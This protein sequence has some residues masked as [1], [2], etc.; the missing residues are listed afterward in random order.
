MC[1]FGPKKNAG[2]AQI[3]EVL[4]PIHW[5]ARGHRLAAY[6]SVWFVLLVSYCLLTTSTFHWEGRWWE[7]LA[8]RQ[9]IGQAGGGRVRPCCWHAWRNCEIIFLTKER[10]RKRANVGWVGGESAIHAWQHATHTNNKWT[11]NTHTH[12]FIH[13][14]AYTHKTYIHI[15]HMDTDTDTDT[16]TRGHTWRRQHVSNAHGWWAA[17][18]WQVLRQSTLCSRPGVDNKNNPNAQHAHTHRHIHINVWWRILASALLRACTQ[19]LKAPSKQ[20]DNSTND[21][22]MNFLCH[23]MSRS[24][25]CSSLSEQPRALTQ[26]HRR[27][28]PSQR[29]RF[30]CRKPAAFW[31][32]KKQKNTPQ[33][34][35]DIHI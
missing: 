30:L 8:G 9:W 26:Q 6:A 34:R 25:P 12:I 2:W 16:A 28:S 5:G 33:N 35:T 19:E 24:R 13:I 21:V 27:R 14:H 1:G 20:T 11:R 22:S 23:C 3:M 7:C 4:Q 18:G 17:D 31:K 15:I 10:Y 32:T 29:G